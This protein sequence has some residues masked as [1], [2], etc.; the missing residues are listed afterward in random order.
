MKLMITWIK[1]NRLLSI[2]ILVCI[3]FIPIVAVAIL[4]VFIGR[5]WVVS[6][7]VWHKK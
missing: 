7:V 5:F 2:I 3:G 6:R 4:I 1:L